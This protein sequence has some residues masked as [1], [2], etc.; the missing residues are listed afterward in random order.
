MKY[1]SKERFILKREEIEQIRKDK[2]NR[3]V[4][5]SRPID[6]YRELI[7]YSIEHYSDHIAYKYNI[8][9]IFVSQHIF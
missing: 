3:K 7:E 8:K 2:K 5:K 1:H 6:N 9:H 4:Y